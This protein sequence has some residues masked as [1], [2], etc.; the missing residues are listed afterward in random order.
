M[1]LINFYFK[2]GIREGLK[3]FTL[4]FDLVL[5]W[6]SFLSLP[7]RWLA[8]GSFQATSRRDALPVCTLQLFKRGSRHT[9]ERQKYAH[10]PPFNI[11]SGRG[12]NI[13]MT[14]DGYKMAAVSTAAANYEL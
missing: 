7:L 9:R 10:S 13:L 14:A 3:H 12:L 11:R 4:Y 5:F 1:L 6:H 8:H 2:H